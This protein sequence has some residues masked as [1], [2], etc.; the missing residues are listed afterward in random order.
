MF[1][2]FRIA[3]ASGTVVLSGLALAAPGE[4][5]EITSKM[6]MPGMPMAMPA[7]TLKICLPLGGERD[8]RHTADKN[9]VVSDVVNSGNKTS[10]KMRCDHNGDIM[11]G[12]GEMTGTRDNAEG[13]MRLSGTSGGKKFDMT[14]SY[15]NRRIGGSCD[16]DEMANKM[17]GMAQAQ[18]C[19]VGRFNLEQKISLSYLMLDEK[20]CPG[21]K[22]PFC[23]SVRTEA[24]RDAKVYAVL[25]ETDKKAKIQVAGACGINMA[26]TTQAICRTVNEGNYGTLTRYCPAEAKLYQDSARRKACEGRSFTGREDLS[27]CLQGKQDSMME[28]TEVTESSDEAPQFKVRKKASNEV[29][30]PSRVLDQAADTSPGINANPGFNNNPGAN[31]NPTPNPTESLLDGARKLKGLFGF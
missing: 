8:P 9:C 1:S 24:V 30:A 3:L 16:T 18:S 15:K 6:E 17:K 23:D 21:K 20:T 4:Y 25:V 11:N 7:T 26:A 12:S 28:S 10:W 22:Q 31:P 19:D 27:R 14:N 2:S 29:T 13:V 5:W